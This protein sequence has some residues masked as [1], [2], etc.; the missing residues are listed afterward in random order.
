MSHPTIR[1][2][3]DGTLLDG[4]PQ[5]IFNRACKDDCVQEG[6][7][8]Q[9]TGTG[10]IIALTAPDGTPATF[11]GKDPLDD[12]EKYL[13]ETWARVALGKLVGFSRRRTRRH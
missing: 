13:K 7:I 12:W 8:D 10:I 4:L 9:T 6:L 5:Y 3:T 11:K 1:L 2:G